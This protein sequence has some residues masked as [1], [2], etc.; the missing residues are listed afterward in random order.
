MFKDYNYM[1]IFDT[2]TTGLT[3]QTDEIIELGAIILK[4]DEGKRKFQPYDEISVL[5]QNFKPILNSHV[6]HITEQMCWE[7][8]ISKDRFFEILEPY[9]G[10]YDDI[11]LV[12]YN[13]PFDMRFIK[14][15][16]SQMKKGY[17]V[18]NPV[19][20]VLKIAK[21]RTGTAKHN[22]LCDMIVRYGVSEENTH[23]ALDDVKA[24]LEVMR[25]M[26]REKPDIERY[27]EK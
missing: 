17:K 15:F 13:A 21:E 9:F 27:I 1:V 26:W 7:K 6:H 19:L 2:E 11:L 3:A 24:T 25:A 20:D 5:V 8:G 14:A 23:R 22:K 4:Y 10:E 12:A 18:T 16:M